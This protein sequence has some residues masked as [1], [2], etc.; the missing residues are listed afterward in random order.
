MICDFIILWFLIMLSVSSAY[1]EMHHNKQ[2][3]VAKQIESLTL[4]FHSV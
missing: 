3:S 2:L 4:T 1:P